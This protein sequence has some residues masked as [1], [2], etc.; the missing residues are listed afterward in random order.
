MARKK[1]KKSAIRPEAA[2]FIKIFDKRWKNKKQFGRDLLF[3]D[4]K[5]YFCRWRTQSKTANVQN[6]S[7]QIQNL[8]GFFL[9]VGSP[10]VAR[11]FLVIRLG[12]RFVQLE[13]IREIKTYIS[14]ISKRAKSYGLSKERLSAIAKTYGIDPAFPESLLNLVGK[15]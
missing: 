14:K 6:I 4:H 8:P 13:G 11:P 9:C 7:D 5:F 15:K 10:L 12:N 2:K 3:L 1:G